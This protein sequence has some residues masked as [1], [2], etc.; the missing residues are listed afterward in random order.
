[1]RSWIG[2]LIPPRRGGWPAERSEAGRVGICRVPGGANF[3]PPP[4]L[5][6]LG[7]PPPLRGG[8]ISRSA[9]FHC[10]DLARGGISRRGGLWVRGRAPP[11]YRHVMEDRRGSWRRRRA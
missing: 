2:F 1:M 6:S 10:P 9:K 3:I 7:H 5:A 8:G 4:G 11:E